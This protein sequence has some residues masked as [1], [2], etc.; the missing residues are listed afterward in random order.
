MKVRLLSPADFELNE[1]VS[2]Y[3]HELPGLGFRFFQEIKAAIERIRFMP[4]AWT[5][6]GEKTRRCLI[7]LSF[8]NKS[9][10][11]ISHANDIH[12]LRNTYLDVLL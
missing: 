2:F 3:D 9:D 7:I 10:K 4:E 11:R 5:K 8:K 1:A 12:V 6:I